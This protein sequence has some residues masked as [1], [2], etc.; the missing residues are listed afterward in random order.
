MRRMGSQGASPG[1]GD[2]RHFG[3]VPHYARPLALNSLKS[4][5][6]GTTSWLTMGGTLHA[7]TRQQPEEKGYGIEG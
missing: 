7:H 5:P 4:M 2:H 6:N 3:M 1:V